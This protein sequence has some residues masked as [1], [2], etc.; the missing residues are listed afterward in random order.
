MGRKQ[1]Q[2]VIVALADLHLARL[3]VKPVQVS[4]FALHAPPRF[5]C[6]HLRRLNK[7]HCFI[8]LTQ[9]YSLMFE[10]KLLHFKDQM[11]W[12]DINTDLKDRTNV[13][14]SLRQRN[15]STPFLKVKL[16]HKV[17]RGYLVNTIFHSR[18]RICTWLCDAINLAK[19]S[20]RPKFEIWLL[21][22]QTQ[23]WTSRGRRQHHFL[24]FTSD[25]NICRLSGDDQ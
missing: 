5:H 9:L 2:H 12:R 15:L 19:V 11:A 14:G 17:C 21:H 25:S 16:A 4:S 22:Q 20:A 3:M 23:R 8:I 10:K 1:K 18:K 6:K 24:P 7:L 13:F